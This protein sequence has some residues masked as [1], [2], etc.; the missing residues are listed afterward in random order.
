MGI[1]D[2]S[3]DRLL[4]LLAIRAR[5]ANMGHAGPN[6]IRQRDS[7][8]PDALG[9]SGEPVHPLETPAAPVKQSKP[10]VAV[11]RPWVSMVRR[12]LPLAVGLVLVALILTR[13][14]LIRLAAT[15]AHA[16]WSW[17]LAAQ[18][19]TLTYILLVSWRWQT[20][21]HL[22]GLQYPFREIFLI[23]NAGALAGA[24]TPGRL[25]DLARLVYFPRQ[26]GVLIPVTLSI[27]A[28]RLLDVFALFGLSLLA[29]NFIPLPASSRHLVV[30]CTLGG[31]MAAAVIILWLRRDGQRLPTMLLR[32]L[33]LAWQPKLEVGIQEFGNALHQYLTWRMIFPGLLTLLAWGANVAGAYCIAD[34]LHIPLGLG[35]VA[36]ILGLSTM[37]TLI[38][39]TFAGLGTREVSCIFL[40]SQLGLPREPALAF[41]LLLLGLVITHAGLG[42]LCL[43]LKPPGSGVRTQSRDPLSPSHAP[44]C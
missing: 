16:H 15:L 38:P 11:R 33:P 42:W 21:L 39:V 17:Y 12:L 34:S 3:S 9:G 32:F 8:P 35:Q 37:F 18:A 14:D 28:D 13:V 30:W 36:A 43:T 5:Y 2:K 23:Y 19:A 41:S 22:Q 1:S 40:F 27:L 31:L 25:G 29:L 10:E 4:K 7:V 26:G 24:V 6:P 44:P 20:L